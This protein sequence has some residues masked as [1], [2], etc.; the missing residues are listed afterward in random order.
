MRSLVPVLVV[1][2]AAMAAQ[3]PNTYPPA[4][5]GSHVDVYHGAK[6]PDPYRWLED[7]DSPETKASKRKTKSRLVFSRACRSARRFA[8][9]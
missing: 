5:A 2:S 3:T 8:S 6:V 4:A 9:A 7:L 1:V